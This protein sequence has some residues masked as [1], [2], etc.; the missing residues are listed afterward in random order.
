M[1]IARE[2]GLPE[3]KHH[4]LPRTKGFILLLQ[5]AQ[6][7]IQSVYDITVA[8][9]TTGADPTL[10]NILKGRSCQAEMFIRRIPIC[11]IPTDTEA[12]SQWVYQLYREKDEIYDYFV[13]H[14][15]FEGNGLPKIEVSRN[16]YD[17]L[18]V[19]GWI[20]IIGIPSIIYFLKF[21][22]TSSYLAQLILVII[23]CIAT[24]VVRAMISVTETERGSHYGVT[25]KK[26]NFEYLII[27]S[28]DIISN[29]RIQYLAS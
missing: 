20:I 13:K 28:F 12:C 23:I 6:N 19:L 16:Y 27:L 24:I 22:L 5:G 15:T 14:G 8:F 17:F 29:K 4:I 7:Q 11:E 3:L 10:V 25:S 1:K 2:K 21:F 9:K 18:I 26:I